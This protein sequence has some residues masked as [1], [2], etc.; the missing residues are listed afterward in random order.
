LSIEVYLGGLLE[1]YTGRLLISNESLDKMCNVV[2]DRI[3]D[4][5]KSL[6]EYSNKDINV[7]NTLVINTFNDLLNI[8]NVKGIRKFGSMGDDIGGLCNSIVDWYGNL[9][10]INMKDLGKVY[11]DLFD[12]ASISMKDKDINGYNKKTA[13]LIKDWNT[14]YNNTYM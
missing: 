6:K 10:N 12:I 4:S 1:L 7:A 3:K 5:V 8:I 11:T 13:M 9:D 2:I 14:F